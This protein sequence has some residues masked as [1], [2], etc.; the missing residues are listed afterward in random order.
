M[1]IKFLY[2]FQTGTDE[3]AQ[4]V[5]TLFSS[6]E[7]DAFKELI[8][9]QMVLTAVISDDYLVFCGGDEADGQEK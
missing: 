2:D 9:G 7:I 5:E 1:L 4:Q 3:I 6:G 8:Q